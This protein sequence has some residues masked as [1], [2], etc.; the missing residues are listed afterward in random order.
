MM[1]TLSA[2]LASATLFVAAP[3]FADGTWAANH[4]RRAQV[5]SRLANQNKRI[6]NGIKD[7]QLT[8]SQA[9]RLHKEDKAIRSE[10][11]ADAA[12]NGGHI[13]KGEQRQINRQENA[14]SRQIHRE[15]QAGK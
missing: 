10:E 8:D 6:D 14:E 13:T 5:N 12:V 2:L 9:R 1:K 7:H 3:A 15:R 11:R 4:P